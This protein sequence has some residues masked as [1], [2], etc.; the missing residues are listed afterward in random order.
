MSTNKEIYFML[1]TI[2]VAD[3]DPGTRI[4]YFFTPWIR[5]EVFPD[6]GLP[7]CFLVR[8]S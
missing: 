4:R 6:P 2:S 5:D 1:F 3:P 7:V 8:F